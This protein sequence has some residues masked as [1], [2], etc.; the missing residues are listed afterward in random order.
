MTLH[1][2]QKQVHTELWGTQLRPQFDPSTERLDLYEMRH[3][4]T[5]EIE[6]LEDQ[7]GYLRQALGIVN[8]HK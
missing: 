4:L 2:I 1:E 7:L 3:K 8:R 6:S 5:Q